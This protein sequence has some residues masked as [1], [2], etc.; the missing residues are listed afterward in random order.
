MTRENRI[1]HLPPF[2]HQQNPNRFSN[3]RGALTL[4]ESGKII[5]PLAFLSLVF[6]GRLEM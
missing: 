2:L 3:Y 5:K 4:H 6:S 1:P